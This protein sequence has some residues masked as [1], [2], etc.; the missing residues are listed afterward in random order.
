M[1]TAGG[2]WSLISVLCRAKGASEVWQ[3]G[4][5][6]TMVA[7]WFYRCKTC[8]STFLK[9]NDTSQILNASL[10]HCSA[11]YLQFKSGCFTCRIRR[12]CTLDGW[13][14]G[15]S[16]HFNMTLMFITFIE[17]IQHT[18]ASMSSK[19]LIRRSLCPCD[20]IFCRIELILC[21]LV[22]GNVRSSCVIPKMTQYL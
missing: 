15:C 1:C 10:W 2:Q 13:G 5:G 21:L 7:P 16:R 4:S 18:A 6:H 17:L 9:A 19:L 3:K 22:S 11:T 14:I 8:T 12:C 20:I